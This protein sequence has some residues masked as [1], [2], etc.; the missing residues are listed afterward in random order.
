MKKLYCP[1]CLEYL[2]SSSGEL[3]DCICGWKQP[4]NEEEEGEE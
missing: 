2:E 4:E 1:E 3:V